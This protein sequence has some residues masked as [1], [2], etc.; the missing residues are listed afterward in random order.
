MLEIKA[1]G[2]TGT[3]RGG[4]CAGK[5]CWDCST[6]SCVL[7]VI[8]IEICI[9]SNRNNIIS[10][11]EGWFVCPFICNLIQSLLFE[12]LLCTILVGCIKRKSPYFQGAYSLVG[13]EDTEIDKWHNTVW[14]QLQVALGDYES[15]NKS[16][17][18]QSDRVQKHSRSGDASAEF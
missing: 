10:E 1:S 18:I 11:D 2:A 12:P 15:S 6:G 3:C 14:K 7:R 16:Y 5:L 4:R 17:L 13:K 8:Q 9:F